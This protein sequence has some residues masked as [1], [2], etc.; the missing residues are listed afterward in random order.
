[1]AVAFI[2]VGRL[3]P[4]P[5][6]PRA[7]VGDI[8]ELTASIRTNGVLQ[9]LTVVKDPDGEM[10]TVIIGHRRLEAAKA[11]GLATVPCNIVNLTPAEQQAMMLTENMQRTDLTMYEQIHGIQMCLDL[12]LTIED[13]SSTTGMSKTSVGNRKRMLQF[14]QAKVKKTLDEG[15]AT[16]QDYLAVDHIGDEAVRA[17]LIE[18]YIGTP[19]FARE[20]RIAQEDQRWKIFQASAERRLSTF[21][22]KIEESERFNYDEVNGWNKWQLKDEHEFIHV[23][24]DYE[25]V[26]YR[27]LIRDYSVSLLKPR[28]AKETTEERKETPRQKMR[29]RWDE[30]IPVIQ[31]FFLS[32]ELGREVFM[33]KLAEMSSEEWENKYGSQ[34]DK[35][36][37][38]ILKGDIE[39][40]SCSSVLEYI[41]N[42]EELEYEDEEEAG[43]GEDPGLTIESERI[44]LRTLHSY[45]PHYLAFLVMYDEMATDVDLPTMERNWE[46]MAMEYSSNR[47]S[48]KMFRDMYE[49]LE[50]Y[51]YKLTDN[52]R[53][54]L[55]GTHP[56]YILPDD[57]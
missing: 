45:S 38:K 40:I 3:H 15:T 43:N 56:C 6:N 49:F 16:M 9:N 23:P 24:E 27:Y 14:D 12:G 47:V 46:T 29:R 54:L 21:A 25:D 18:K 51:G 17:K 13:I 41:I 4:H 32:A 22:E 5:K 11:A 30:Y 53:M 42:M 2:P 20:L 52:E 10:Y 44:V 55:D 37:L 33:E 7:S 31:N 1:M 19:N 28:E 35:L 50:E 36:I 48:C 57:E 34:V 26:K 39:T 8:T